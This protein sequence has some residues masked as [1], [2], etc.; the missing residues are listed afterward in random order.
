MATLHSIHFGI[1]A[2]GAFP[3]RQLPG[4]VRDAARWREVMTELFGPFG[5]KVTPANE[6]PTEGAELLRCVSALAAAMGDDDHLVITFSGHGAA[7]RNP[8][9]G[10]VGAMLALCPS[11]VVDGGDGS[12]HGVVHL[13]ELVMA[14]GDRADATT[15]VVDACYGPPSR[16]RMHRILGWAEALAPQLDGHDLRYFRDARILLAC[17]PGELAW[18]MP[19]GGRNDRVQMDGAFSYALTTLMRRWTV[20]ADAVGRAFLNV[21]YGDLVEHVRRLLD[22]YGIEQRPLLLGDPGLPLVPVF[23]PGSAFWGLQTSRRPDAHLLDQQI[24]S[25]HGGN[26]TTFNLWVDY[27]VDFK[28]LGIVLAQLLVTSPG[29]VTDDATPPVATLLPNTEYWHAEKFPFD[30]DHRLR[31]LRFEVVELQGDYGGANEYGDLPFGD[32]RSFILGSAHM[33]AASNFGEGNQWN[34]A[35]DPEDV[36]WTERFYPN[37]DNLPDFNIALGFTSEAIDYRLTHIRWEVSDGAKQLEF[38]LVPDADHR[39][40]RFLPDK[41]GPSFTRTLITRVGSV[42]TGG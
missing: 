3:D 20:R 2:Y 34:S 25:D 21:G 24:S 4:A 16:R 36:Q 14:L 13:W 10:V 30:K 38:L 42:P 6:T 7:V 33:V 15:I 41:K 37:S 22:V 29:S 27:E 19:T 18:E 39:V 11:D 32:G 40:F 5:A 28:E 35:H 1:G 8:A 12:I 23:H 9:Q 26:Y 17:E 31:S